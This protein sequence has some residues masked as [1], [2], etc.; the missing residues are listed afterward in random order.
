MRRGAFFGMAMIFL[1][2]GCGY[3]RKAVL[4]EGIKTIYVDTVK[5]IV[6]VG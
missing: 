5:N 6:P 3:T 4:P 1:F 2:N